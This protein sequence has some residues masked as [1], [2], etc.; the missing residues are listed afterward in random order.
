MPLTH[1]SIVSIGGTGANNMCRELC[2]QLP[3]AKLPAGRSLDGSS[4]GVFWG[5]LILRWNETTPHASHQ[6]EMRAAPDLKLRAL[7]PA[8][9]RSV[10]RSA[11][12]RWTWDNRHLR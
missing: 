12:H 5:G 3:I 11:R 8:A 10:C 6:E 1:T 7:S 9:P 4:P 2:E